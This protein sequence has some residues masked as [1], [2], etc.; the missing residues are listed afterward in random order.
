MVHLNMKAQNDIV[1]D[2][3]KP[4][5]NQLRSYE[6]IDSLYII[7]SYA[8]NFTFD[9]PFPPDIE[10]PRNF[11]PNDE[12]NNRRF[13]GIPE[14]QQ[15]FLLKEMLINCDTTPT[16]YTLREKDKLAKLINYVRF[17]LFEEIDKR[18]RNPDDILL[19]FNR[20]SHQQFIWQLG[21]TPNTIFRFYKVFSDKKVDPLIQ[22]VFKLST[23]E[24]FIM[25]FGFFRIT[26]EQFRTS[27][28]FTSTV[29]AITNEMIEIFFNHFS[30]SVEQAKKVLKDQQQMNE[31]LFY[32]YNP[33]LATPLLTYKNTFLCPI[34]LFLFWKVAGGLYYYIYNSK[35]FENAFGGSFERYIGE[36]LSLSCSSKKFN[37]IP[38]GKYGKEEK[39][40]VDW[41]LT[42]DN[43][44]LFIECKTKRMTLG[45]KT[46]LDIKSGL[47]NDL[48]KMA[49]FVTQVYKTYLDYKANLYPSVK[50]DENKKFVPLVV[51][52]EAW[53]IN[54][55]PQ[56]MKQLH[57]LIIDNFKSAG[58]DLILLDT[59]PYYL[60]S[61]DDLERDIQLINA[62][63]IQAYFEKIEKKELHEY[64]KGF[65]YKNVFEGEFEKTF[66][67]PLKTPPS[68]K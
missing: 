8:R 47:E 32:T 34:P 35:G 63:G 37:V 27:L 59:N 54:L 28:P 62:L 15:D 46:D 68:K 61:A 40:T 64:I 49:G 33:L 31:N 25:A 1:F 23:Y 45:A 12:I 42:D 16:K 4:F 58:L 43:G 7:W 13:F 50:Y 52:L 39:E 65:K 56:L 53:Y 14:F 38:A 9:L 48:K 57:G 22:G 2:L 3:Y 19:E 36:V 24:L 20:M 30:I 18:F 21:Y 66:I 41:L 26:A 55:N 29:P 51:T 17:S 60:R 11:H 67:E 44:I 6:L 5:R 10:F